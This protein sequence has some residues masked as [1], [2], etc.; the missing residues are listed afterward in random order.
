M[1]RFQPL[2]IS[3][4][5]RPTLRDHEP[6][7]LIQNHVGLY[8]GNKKDLAHN[9]GNLYL[10]PLRLLYVDSTRP[11]QRSL[12]LELSLVNYFT[13]QSGFLTSSPKLTLYLF[14]PSSI[15]ETDS[16]QHGALSALESSTNPHNVYSVPGGVSDN[17]WQCA[18]CQTDNLPQAAKCVLCG[19]INRNSHGNSL[20]PDPATSSRLTT[21]N[22]SGTTSRA[23]PACT[24][25]NHPSMAYCEL[26]NTSLRPKSNKDKNT[27]PSQVEDSISSPSIS[28]SSTA[29]AE[30][31]QTQ[32]K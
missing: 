6:I 30:S 23:C 12:S 10:T 22:K 16:S 21:V 11:H 7:L 2:T 20:K 29:V 8:Q 4:S 1:N 27:P 32:I 15:S 26:C 3:L 17:I 14:H 13:F 18:I 5:Q 24:F 25:I 19:V 9:D 28:S 31:S